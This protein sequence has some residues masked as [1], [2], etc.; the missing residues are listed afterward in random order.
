M[1]SRTEGNII[2]AASNGAQSC[3]KLVV[4]IL[5]NLLIFTSLID[6]LD[7]TFAWFGDRVGID[8]LTFEV[9]VCVCVFVVYDGCMHECVS[10]SI[11]IYS[12]AV[13]MHK[14]GVC[15]L[16]NIFITIIIKCHRTD[17]CGTPLL[18]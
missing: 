12:I 9:C 11:Y 3:I 8:D 16:I 14:Y 1:I 15:M 10:T 13:I 17:L 7:H 6:F 4:Y 2:E 5:V 18:H